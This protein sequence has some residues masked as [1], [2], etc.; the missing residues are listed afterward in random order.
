M[1]DTM[2]YLETIYPLQILI[3]AILAGSCL[4]YSHQATRNKIHNGTFPIP[5]YRIGGKRVVK[6]TDLVKYIDS[7]NYTSWKKRGRPN[8]VV[9]GGGIK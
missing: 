2:A 1:T 4:G 6:K 9:N 5:T 7:L 3:P 8:K